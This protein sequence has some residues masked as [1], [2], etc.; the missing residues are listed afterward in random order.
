MNPPWKH[1]S[2]LSGCDAETG[3]PYSHKLLLVTPEQEERLLA[4]Y[5]AVEGIP[6]EAL[7]GGAVKEL[8]DSIK[9]A[10]LFLESPFNKTTAASY[11][12]GIRL[13]RALDQLKGD[14]NDQ[15]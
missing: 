3:H 4:A 11:L 8:V 12:S 6:T 14:P 13:D 5:E 9:N 10:R 15:D 1:H 2:T 7:K